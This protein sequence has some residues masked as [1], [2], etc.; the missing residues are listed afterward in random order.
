M[1]PAK[2]ISFFIIYLSLA[3]WCWE[4]ETRDERRRGRGEERSGASEGVP[5]EV[6]C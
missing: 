2:P 3:W 4:P 1:T 5:E 6:R